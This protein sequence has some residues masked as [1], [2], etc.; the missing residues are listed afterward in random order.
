MDTIICPICSAE[1]D[2]DETN[3]GKCGANLK[4]KQEDPAQLSDYKQQNAEV[5]GVPQQ[6]TTYG[7]EPKFL[8][9]M[10]RLWGLGLCAFLPILLL[11]NYSYMPEREAPFQLIMFGLYVIGMLI[12]WFQEMVG[13][14]IALVGCIGIYSVI[15]IFERENFQ[16]WIGSFI[17]ILPPILFLLASSLLQRNMR[18]KSAQE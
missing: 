2:I 14:L 9:W 17:F 4:D 13:A 3:C 10:G 7:C 16:S 15:W 18:M 12:S 6:T 5:A 11:F 1:N 8:R